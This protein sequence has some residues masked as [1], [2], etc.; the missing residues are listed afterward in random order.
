MS[1]SRDLLTT[2]KTTEWP[3]TA[4]AA[5]NEYSCDTGRKTTLSV[6]ALYKVNRLNDVHM[7]VGLWV[8]KCAGK[9]ETLLPGINILFT[10]IMTSAHR[11]VYFHLV[12][13]GLLI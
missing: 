12:Y 9:I 3:N 10:W 1:L 6:K 8:L 7:S 13:R 2:L 5:M 4:V 11:P